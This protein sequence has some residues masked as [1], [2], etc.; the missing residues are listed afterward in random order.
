MPNVANFIVLKNVVYYEP[1]EL[2]DKMTQR[3]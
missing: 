3:W 1:E 2:M